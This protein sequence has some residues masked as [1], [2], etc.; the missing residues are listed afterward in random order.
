VSEQQFAARL[1][2]RLASKLQIEAGPEFAAALER[3][4]AAVR[5]DN[6]RAHAEMLRRSEIAK[7]GWAK[8]RAAAAI[9]VSK[10]TTP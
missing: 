5:I 9:K 10:E 2:A 6:E 3:Y 7:A 4:E 8:R 1:V